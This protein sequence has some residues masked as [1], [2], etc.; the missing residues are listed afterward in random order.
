MMAQVRSFATDEA[1]RTNTR[2]KPALRR[3]AARLAL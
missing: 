2:R 1:E 3:K